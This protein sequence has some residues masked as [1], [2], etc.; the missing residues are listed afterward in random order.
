MLRTR[1]NEALK[2]SMR[3][4][5]ARAVSTIRMVLAGLK[6][7]D[8][9]ARTRGVTDGIDEPEILSMMQGLIKQRNESATMYDQ[10]GRPE[11]AQQEREE[12]AVIEGFLPKQMSEDE[13]KAALD[14]IVAELGASSIKDMGRVMAELKA[15]HAG[16][17]D[18]AKAGGLV[19]QTLSG[20]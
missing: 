1:L 14:A 17:M 13:V 16:Q 5:D 15:R 7:R 3:A 8:I 11:L 9:A 20:K 10:G 12:I 6:D 19:K 4:K 2:E 18:F